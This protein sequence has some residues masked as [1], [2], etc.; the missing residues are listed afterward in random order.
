[1]G[2]APGPDNADPRFDAALL[3]IATAATAAG[4]V[5]GIH[6]EPELVTKRKEQG[7]RMITIGYDLGPMLRALH[8]ALATG[9]SS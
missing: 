7:F 8:G 6:A 4:I 5:P 1:M 3:R 2:L 9:R